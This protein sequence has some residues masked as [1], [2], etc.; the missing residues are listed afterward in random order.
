MEDKGFRDD[1]LK[2]KRNAK[3]AI[4]RLVQL[5]NRSSHLI[6]MRSSI[7]R[8]SVSTSTNASY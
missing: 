1:F 3:Q 8:L 5:V 6:R 2:A 7:A 4:L